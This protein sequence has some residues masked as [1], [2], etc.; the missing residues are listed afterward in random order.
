MI[1]QATT[2]PTTIQAIQLDGSIESANEIVGWAKGLV[3]IPPHLEDTKN[4]ILVVPTDA[5]YLI[6]RK[7]SWIIKNNNGDFYLCDDT[8]FS[9][10]YDIVE[11]KP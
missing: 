3:H 10:S 1:I 5:G 2:K 9:K 8:L 11:V 4:C 7:G 6:A